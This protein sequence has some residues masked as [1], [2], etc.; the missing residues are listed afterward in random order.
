MIPLKPDTISDTL[1]IKHT[2]E[3]VQADD[4]V[5]NETIHVDKLKRSF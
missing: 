5:T 4:G 3:T 1:R 2:K